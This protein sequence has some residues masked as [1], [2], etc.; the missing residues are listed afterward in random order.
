MFRV[1]ATCTRKRSLPEGSC[2]GAR[3]GSFGFAAAV[4]ETFSAGAAGTGDDSGR[5][6]GGSFRAAFRDDSWNPGAAFFPRVS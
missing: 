3:D 2:D 1:E 6:T 4:G 5:T